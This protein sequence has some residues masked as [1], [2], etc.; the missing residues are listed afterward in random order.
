M[1]VT[2]IVGILCLVGGLFLLVAGLMQSQK[3]KKAQATWQ[4]TEGVIK[5]S[6]LERHSNSSGSFRSATYTPEVTYHY[7]VNGKSYEGYQFAFGSGSFSHDKAEEMIAPY[8][9]ETRV[10]VFYDPA[11]PSKAV[12]QTWAT[13][14]KSSLIFG[15]ILIVLGVLQLVL[16][17]T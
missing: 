14:Q 16:K 7:T 11:D 17:F 3:A 6:H 9:P 2:L 10:Q 15:I 5:G 12:L 13:S 1:D 8:T 4:T